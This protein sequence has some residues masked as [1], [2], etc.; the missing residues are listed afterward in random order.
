MRDRK[1]LLAIVGAIAFAGIGWMMN[2]G[3]ISIIFAAVLGLISGIY[4]GSK[5]KRRLKSSDKIVAR[6]LYIYY[7]ESLFE[8]THLYLDQYKFCVNTSRQI[9]ENVRFNEP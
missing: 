9:I 4:L 7:L 6:T 2:F 8:T 1:I 5:M 3:W